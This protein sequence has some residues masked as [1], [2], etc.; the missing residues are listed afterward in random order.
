MDQGPTGGQSTPH[1]KS[2]SSKIGIPARISD[3]AQFGSFN[4]GE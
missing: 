2:F 3:D 4:G 1:Y